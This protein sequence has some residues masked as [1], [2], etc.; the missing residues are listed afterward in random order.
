MDGKCGLYRYNCEAAALIR[1]PAA[2]LQNICCTCDCDA[3][4]CRHVTRLYVTVAGTEPA[5][6]C[7][8]RVAL[9]WNDPLSSPRLFDGGL[10]ITSKRQLAGIRASKHVAGAVSRGAAGAA[11]RARSP[12][13]RVRHVVLRRVGGRAA[14]TTDARGRFDDESR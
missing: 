11:H 10:V 1:V 9:I 12:G 8:D 13:R 2:D 6:H 3:A 4:V 7:V 5:T 14:E